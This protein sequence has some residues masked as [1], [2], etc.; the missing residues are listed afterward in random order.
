[1]SET[2]TLTP[3]IIEFFKNNAWPLVFDNLF[4]NPA[5]IGVM[6]AIAFAILCWGV[7]HLISLNL[8]LNF[9]DKERAYNEGYLEGFKKAVEELS[10]VTHAKR[11]DGEQ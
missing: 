3:E 5:F 9:G 8:T 4:K 1:M 10:Q 7:S 2:T 11:T 6:A